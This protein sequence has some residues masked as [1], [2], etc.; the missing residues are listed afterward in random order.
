[1]PLKQMSFDWQEI[2]LFCKL[3]FVVHHN[4]GNH[5]T[6]LKVLL[7]VLQIASLN[8]SISSTRCK[9]EIHLILY[10]VNSL[11]SSSSSILYQ[12]EK[13]P[14]CHTHLWFSSPIFISQASPFFTL[15]FALTY[16]GQPSNMI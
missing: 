6:F 12:K 3:P 14:W 8:E 5:M 11:H 2:S 9:S 13:S 16:R 7:E 15:C 1:M 4:R 10:K